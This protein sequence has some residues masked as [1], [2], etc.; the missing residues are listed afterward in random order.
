MESV[1][2]RRVCLLDLLMDKQVLSQLRSQ[3]SEHEH[4]HERILARFLDFTSLTPVR[5]SSRSFE[6]PHQKRPRDDRGR[7]E[8]R[9]SFPFNSHHGEL[10][11]DIVASCV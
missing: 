8:N 9:Y 5:M 7:Y 3:I 6:V 2:E 11:V 4:E 10:H 1:S